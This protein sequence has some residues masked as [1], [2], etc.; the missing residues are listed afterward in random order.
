M[1]Q[2][3]ADIVESSDKGLVLPSMFVLVSRMLRRYEQSMV[4][5]VFLCTDLH[6]YAQKGRTPLLAALQY[7]DFWGVRNDDST[8]LKMVEL[9]ADKGASLDAADLARK[10]PHCSAW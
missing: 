7:I 8:N 9:L 4:H 6:V 10:A 1:G 2:G 3:C 5:A